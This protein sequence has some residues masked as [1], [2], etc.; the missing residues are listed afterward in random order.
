MIEY[1]NTGDS[2]YIGHPK[3]GNGL[4]NHLRELKDAFSNNSWFEK[5]NKINSW[6]DFPNKNKSS[7]IL[8]KSLSC[9]PNKN[10]LV[11]KNVINNN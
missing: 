7:I 3:L 9:F 8:I 11:L 4:S 10:S 5:L 6:R 1:I 2:H